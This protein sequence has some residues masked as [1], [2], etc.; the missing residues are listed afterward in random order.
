MNKKSIMEK[1]L[2]FGKFTLI[3]RMLGL[4]REV[5]MGRILG[6][7][8]LGIAF[9]AAF[10]LPNSLRKIFAEGALTAAFVPTF[11]NVLKTEGKENANKLFSTAFV[12][13]EGVLILLCLFVFCC[14]KWVV[15]FSIPGEAAKTIAYAAPLLKILMSFIL[16]I[17]SSALFA[18]ALQAKNHFFLPAFSPI[19]FNIFFIAGIVLSWIFGYSIDFLCYM[20]LAGGL[21]QFL[22]HLLAYYN[23]GF[24]FGKIDEHS[25][26]NFEKV[27]VKFFPVMFSMSILEVNFFVDGRMASY[28]PKG[29]AYLYY[30]FRFM[31]IALG[32]VGVSF[33]TVL[34]PH[35]SRVSMYAPKRLNF[36]LLESSKFIFWVIA[37]VVI[38]MSFFSEEIFAT[39]LMSENFTYIDVLSCKVILRAFL[40]G[41]FF[42]SLNKI[43]LNVYYA[44]HNTIS[45]AII[46]IIGALSNILLNLLLGYYWQT[47]GLALATSLS[48]AITTILLMLFLKSKYGFKM[49][50]KSFFDFAFRYSLQM[51][52]MFSIFFIFYFSIKHV[53]TFLPENINCFFTKQFGIWTWVGPL[54]CLLFLL[55]YKTKK[56]FKVRLYFLS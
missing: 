18:G 43:I 14:P 3:S 37:P 13:F 32:V 51:I 35:F 12:V 52:C 49:H 44:R 30:S 48:G 2:Q 56:L 4:A 28:Y 1:T 36:Y 39:L 31:G 7:T 26:K 55:L 53:L 6:T 22:L 10:K 45:P 8:P 16:F 9:I 50:L 27:L 15:S 11:V 40:I 17:S 34:L 5:L 42:F 21:V 25:W 24:K 20:I 46:S 33:A 41:L 19:L 23:L 29:I 54:S 47:V 38:L